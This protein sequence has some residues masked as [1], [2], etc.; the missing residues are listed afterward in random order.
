MQ[1]SRI[2]KAENEDPGTSSDVR[3]LRIRNSGNKDPGTSFDVRY[4]RSRNSGNKDPGTSF[5][6]RYLRSRNSGNKDSGTRYDVRNWRGRNSGNKDSGT[7]FDVRNFKS[8]NSENKDSGTRSDVRNWRGRNSGNKASGTCPNWSLGLV[9]TCSNGRGWRSTVRNSQENSKNKDSGTSSI[10]SA[11][12]SRGGRRF[13]RPRYPRRIRRP[14]NFSSEYLESLLEK[15]LEEVIQQLSQNKDFFVYI[16]QELSSDDIVLMVKHL[17]RFCDCKFPNLRINI[18][19][20]SLTSGF[21]D[22]LQLFI[23]DIAFQSIEDE[24]SNVYYW[25]D[26]DSFWRNFSKFCTVSMTESPHFF[27]DNLLKLVKISVLNIEEIKKQHNLHIETKDLQALIDGAEKIKANFQT[28]ESSKP[29]TLVYYEEEPPEDFHEISIFPTTYEL[30]KTKK[31]FVRKNVVVGP[32]RDVNHYLDVQFRLLREDFVGPLR[33][34]IQDLLSGKERRDIQDIK[35]HPQVQFLNPVTVTGD[36]CVLLKF[37]FG[38]QLTN[39]KFE[40]SKKFMF[41]SLVCFTNDNFKTILFGRIADRKKEYLEKGELVIGFSKPE[42][43]IYNSDY[44]MVECGIYFEPYYHVLNVLKGIVEEEFPMK[45]YIVDVDNTVIMP[46]FGD[47][48]VPDEEMN[49]LYQED[50]W[51]EGPNPTVSELNESQNDAYDAALTRQLSIIQGPPGTGKTFVGL[52][53][54]E[55]LLKN[56]RAWH[57]DSPIL[58]ICFTNH[59]LDQFLE[60]IIEH[61]DEIVRIGGQSKN[62]KLKGFQLNELSRDADF[63]VWDAK[64]EVKECLELIKGVTDS[65]R[66]IAS[67]DCIL[68]LGVFAG[69]VPNFSRSWLARA[70]EK[71][72]LDW[73][74]AES[75]PN[76]QDNL[77]EDESFLLSQF[78]NI[79]IEDSGGNQEEE[80][81]AR[82]EFYDIIANMKSN[83][84]KPLLDLEELRNRIYYNCEDMNKLRSQMEND[85]KKM[86]AYMYLEAQNERLR[87]VINIVKHNMA[88][89]SKRSAEIPKTDIRYSRYIPVNERWN[90]YFYWI[91]LYKKKLLRMFDDYNVKYRKA[92]KVYNELKEISDIEILRGAKL[93]G[94]TTTGAARLHSTLQVLKCPI[95]IVEEAAE[96]LEAHVVAAL[97]S[98][99]QQLILIGDHQQLRPSTGNYVMER[100]YNLGISLFER[101]IR[102]DVQCFTLNVQHRMRPEISA[103]IKPSIYPD[104]QDH[105]SVL[106]RPPI[107]GMDKCLYFIDHQHPEESSAGNSKK[108]VHEATFLVRLAEYLMLNGY[109]PGQITILAAYLSQMY[110]IQREK[111]KIDLLGDVRVAVLDNYQGEESDIIL[112]SLVRNNDENRIG[113]LA[114]DNRVCVAL[115]RARNGFYIMGNMSILCEKSQLWVKVKTTLTAQ[116]AIGPSLA[117]KCQNHDKITMVTTAADF[118]LVSEGGCDVICDASLI[119]GH[120]CKRRCHNND[121]DHEKYF[122]TEK[123]NTFLCDMNPTHLCIKS[124]SEDC[125]PCNYPKDVTLVCGHQAVIPCHLAPGDYNC[126]IE[127][128]VTLPCGHDATKPCHMADDSYGCTF[129]CNARLHCGHSCVKKCHVLQDPDHLTYRCARPCTKFGKGCTNLKD[130]DHMCHKLCFEPCDPCKKIVKKART[131]CPHFFDVPCSENVDDIVCHKPCK[132]TFDCGHPCKKRC[133]ESCGTCKMMVEKVIPGCDHTSQVPCSEEPSKAYCNQ[134]CPRLMECGHVCG[135][136]CRDPCDSSKCK[137]IVD[138]SIPAKCGHIVKRAPCFVK[139]AYKTDAS[140]I[141]NL[142]S[143]C[144]EP[145]TAILNCSPEVEHPCR[146]TCGSC[147]QGRIHESCSHKCGRTLIC[148]HKCPGYC[149]EPCKPCS[150]KCSFRCRHNVCKK[151]C[152]DPC[153]V[154][155]EP[156]TRRCKHR[157]CT[158]KCGELCDVPPCDAPCE[159]YLKCGHPC[160]GFCGEPCPPLCRI[161]DEDGVKEV[162]FGTEDG[163]DARFVLLRD[164]GHVL[165]NT[166]MLGWLEQEQD[167]IGFKV[168][169]KCKTKILVTERYSDY[170]KKAVR[171]IAAAKMKGVG[172]YGM[173]KEKHSEL[174]FE[175][176]KLLHTHNLIHYRKFWIE[177]LQPFLE[178]L[179]ITNKKGQQALNPLK[180]KAIEIKH[181]LT[182]RVYGILGSLDL[183]FVGKTDLIS[184]LHSQAD[185]ILTNLLREVDNITTVEVEDIQRE[186]NRLNRM[187]QISP[188]LIK[189]KSQE[190]SL[191]TRIVSLND[192]INSLSKYDDEKDETVKKE[193]SDLR[194]RLSLSD[195]TELEKTQLV[196]IRGL[197][198]GNW[199]QCPNG[200][201]Y[202]VGEV[203]SGMQAS[204]CIECG[205]KP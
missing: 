47:P 118:S 170:V 168:C 52:K 69:V 83:L 126:L 61:T 106:H 180:L 197:S 127:V 41:G 141:K 63:S 95:V 133:A 72:F 171:G 161:C 142:E 107:E 185:L 94:M 167:A 21:V 28:E 8:R 121:K 96:I 27:I 13:H 173:V 184:P 186:I 203:G 157:R 19:Q 198:K 190:E 187:V 196:G 135:R 56:S 97:T 86:F 93:I 58:V 4:L 17:A 125:G 50:D 20:T 87:A 128:Q 15:P 55:T 14:T 109:R 134:K 156:C 147:Y 60:S 191:R 12:E 178:R 137:E 136:I 140:S 154:C 38:G 33:H 81:Y 112:L 123:C 181:Q 10:R 98:S 172:T 103:L 114:N 188:L 7:R 79:S 143:Y 145:C 89:A 66:S 160:V 84:R 149:R 108:N 45:N 122:C 46:K 22:N 195:I 116:E 5:D 166:G 54:V 51:D 32:Y 138:V 99:C 115:S 77:E 53:I 65:L 189:M 165:E 192:L 71:E 117:L 174:I 1:G 183:R 35:I 169:P 24:D 29:K 2:R 105:E 132:K 39:F 80:E 144:S 70:T 179:Q 75:I 100:F 37:H 42:V 177:R 40:D 91:S 90:L 193:L 204:Q 44:V 43:L 158:K 3:D 130:E 16:G 57:K 25:D 139:T 110:E 34:G 159:K 164:C 74:L 151:R 120:K 6:V 111:R 131:V 162:F 73:L 26:P 176:K 88:I 205:N 85:E 102:N 49:E 199:F 76:I 148:D 155:K 68:N 182:K 152:G 200:H 146:G 104:L 202:V 119:C 30:V 129:P 78:R 36:Y 163:D 201:A 59:A 92:F 175:Y 124:C 153:F 11:S 9:P 64:D 82:D 18:L 62:E 194:K 150:S 48:R 67:H 31:P 23:S 101:M 113:F